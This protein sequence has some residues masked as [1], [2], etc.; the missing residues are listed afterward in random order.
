MIFVTI[1]GN[2]DEIPKQ[3]KTWE[4]NETKCPSPTWGAWFPSLS[5]TSSAK[6]KEHIVVAANGEDET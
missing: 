6:L 4:F 3:R 1:Y 5:S 2:K